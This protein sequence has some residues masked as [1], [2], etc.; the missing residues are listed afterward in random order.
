[1][2]SY[3]MMSLLFVFLIAFCF[4]QGSDLSDLIQNPGDEALVF[5]QTRIRRE[6]DENDEDDEWHDENGLFDFGF[7]DFLENPTEVCQESSEYFFQGWVREP[8]RNRQWK[9]GAIV[10][11]DF[12]SNGNPF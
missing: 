2:S 7:D 1:M 10:R 4:A 9:K 3:T 11:K 5:D 12:L 6:S 8:L